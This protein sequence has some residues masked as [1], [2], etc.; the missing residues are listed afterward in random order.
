MNKNFQW[1]TKMV[2]IFPLIV[3]T[4]HAIGGNIDDGIIIV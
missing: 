4:M 3:M 2:I 1:M